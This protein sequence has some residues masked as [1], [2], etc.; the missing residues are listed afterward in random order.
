MHV[1]TVVDVNEECSVAQISLTLP[2]NLVQTSGRSIIEVTATKH[3][4]II[5]LNSNTS[6][7]E[8]D[9]YS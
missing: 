8:V 2:Q 4:G 5:V 7:Q 1:L 3:T 6:D 9:G